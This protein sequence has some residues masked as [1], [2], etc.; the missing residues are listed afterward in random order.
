MNLSLITQEIKNIFYRNNMILFSKNINIIKRFVSN[1]KKGIKLNALPFKLTPDEAY[2]ILNQNQ[3]IFEKNIMNEGKLEKAFFPMLSASINNVYTKYHLKYGIDRLE[4]MTQTYIDSKGHLHT[5]VVPYVVTDWHNLSG[6]I[7]PINYSDNDIKCFHKYADFEYPADFIENIV[8]SE[9]MREKIE[10]IVTDGKTKIF[11]HEKKMSFAI[12]QIL[13]NLRECEET[14]LISIIKQK[15]GADHIKI[16]SMHLIFDNVEI[17]PFSYYVPI[18]LY[19]VKL[20]ETKKICKIINGHNGN[21]AGDYVVSELKFGMM[22]T[23]LGSLLGFASFYI[24]PISGSITSLLLLRIGTTGVLSGVISSIGSNFY[25]KY[26]YDFRRE[27]M[28]LDKEINIKH[29]ETLEDLHR[30]LLLNKS[31]K[32]DYMQYQKEFDLLGL[33]IEEELTIQKLKTAKIIKLK[34]YHPDL[35]SLSKKETC[36]ILT[37]QILKAYE[38]LQKILD[39]K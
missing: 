19:V 13:K 37:D 25:S 9:N 28:K 17:L 16:L 1:T 22:G 4:Y 39:K 10:E 2:N 30:K 3:G 34:Q 31:I 8:Q 21:Y 12:D 32:F 35:N 38:T 27:S 33:D 24:F 29:D 5:R 7:A 20:E 36:T 14:R 18:Y 6:K 23:F 15:T 11:S 26:K